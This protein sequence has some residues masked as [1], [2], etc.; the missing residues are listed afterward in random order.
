MKIEEAVLMSAVFLKLT[1]RVVGTDSESLDKDLPTPPLS[2][3]CLVKFNFA[4]MVSNFF[5]LGLI[6]LHDSFTGGD[7]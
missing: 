5:Q 6:L 7:D 1:H 3:H 4:Y 2:L